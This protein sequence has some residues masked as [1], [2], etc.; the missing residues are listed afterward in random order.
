MLMQLVTIDGC[1]WAI[2]I[3]RCSLAWPQWQKY[4]VHFKPTGRPCR[5]HTA[6]CTWS[7]LSVQAFREAIIKRRREMVQVNI[8][9]PIILFS[10][11]G[12]VERKW[13]GRLLC[14]GL[15]GALLVSWSLLMRS[16]MVKENALTLCMNLRRSW[17]CS[18]G[19][20]WV[21][22]VSIAVHFSFP[23]YFAF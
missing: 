13:D 6:A 16:H 23:P 8:K 4:V 2:N 3:W 11:C 9:A 15:R 18:L 19:R 22:I 12:R 14:D 17:P 5:T 21:S 20:I 10:R 7:P 1:E